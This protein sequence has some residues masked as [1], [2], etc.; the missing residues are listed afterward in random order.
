MR[1]KYD[2]E[3]KI[4]LCGKPVLE[5]NKDAIKL[6]LWNRGIPLVQS[7]ERKL[8]E[9]VESMAKKNRIFARSHCRS[10]L[11]RTRLDCV[12]PEE[13]S[14]VRAGSPPM[15]KYLYVD[16]SRSLSP[17]TMTLHKSGRFY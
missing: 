7:F 3:A 10:P 16:S 2:A 11:S 8:E 4:R 5:D 15:Y 13:L 12:F 9:S 14:P 1:I 6:K 17:S